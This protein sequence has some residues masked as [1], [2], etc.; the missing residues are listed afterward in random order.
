MGS[1]N[2]KGYG[3]MSFEGRTGYV[4]RFILELKLGHPLP[5][6]IEA[7]HTCDIPP[8]ANPYHLFPGTH[9]QNMR[10]SANKGRAKQQVSYG[11]DHPRAALNAEQ[12]AMIRS[13]TGR[14]ATIAREM[15]LTYSVVYGCRRRKTYNDLA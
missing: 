9:L 13:A 10:D 1:A 12:V 14:T 7:C 2:N 15:G 5:R 3:T 8:C 6:E 4:H 11:I